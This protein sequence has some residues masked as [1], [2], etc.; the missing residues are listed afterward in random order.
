MVRTAPR[1]PRIGSGAS[2]GSA[3]PA[4]QRGHADEPSEARGRRP[5]LKEYGKYSPHRAAWPPDPATGQL[6][7]GLDGA[8]DRS[9]GQLARSSSTR[10]GEWPDVFA[11][12]QLDAD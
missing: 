8:E 7:M 5:R 12:D 4:A 11:V 2:V 9:P 10:L 1:G 6:E 3:R